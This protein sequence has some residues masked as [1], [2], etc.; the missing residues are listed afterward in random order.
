MRLDRFALIILAAAIPFAAAAVPATAAGVGAVVQADALTWMPAPG[1]PPGAQ[2]AVLYGDPSKE[3]P[4]TVRFK[5]PAGYEI[6]THSH[7]TDE[8]LTV[9]SGTA[10]MAFGED[11]A[12]G[13]AQPMVAGTFTSL[14]A[15]SWH[16]LWI[17]AE[18]IVELSSTG[19][20]AVHV[21]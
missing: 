16:H 8:F 1:L 20:F 17:D 2:M 19:P 6:P 4:F 15:G 3:G 14:P 5:F 9:I 18:A 10:R 7:P 12:K 13:A 11:A 21:H